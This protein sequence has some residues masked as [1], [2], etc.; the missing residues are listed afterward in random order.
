MLRDCNEFN[1]E[2]K[3][4]CERIIGST[5]RPGFKYILRTDP[6]TQKWIEERTK[7]INDAVKDIDA[8]LSG[9]K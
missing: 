9:N 7:E 5:Y 2:R 8:H 4:E 1:P 6:C 3:S